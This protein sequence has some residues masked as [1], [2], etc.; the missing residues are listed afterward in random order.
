[1][2]SAP[3]TQFA[4]ELGVGMQVP[5]EKGEGLDHRLLLLVL[6]NLGWTHF[7][8]VR[9]IPKLSKHPPLAQEVPAL[10]S[11]VEFA[12]AG[13]CW[14]VLRSGSDPSIPNNPHR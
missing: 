8:F 11:S 2:S 13:V 4:G 1:M 7:R 3:L 14:T 10:V 6:D 12:D 5:V 9:I